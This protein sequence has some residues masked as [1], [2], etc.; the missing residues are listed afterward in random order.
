MNSGIPVHMV[1][2]AVQWNKP[3]DD[4]RVHESPWD[5]QWGLSRPPSNQ[6]GWQQIMMDSGKLRRIRQD[7]WI[8]TAE[9]GKVVVYSEKQF[10]GS[11]WEEWPTE[12]P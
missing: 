9:G 10:L 1:A 11:A 12:V 2:Y 4:P 7:D 6:F 3:G 5:P 8:V